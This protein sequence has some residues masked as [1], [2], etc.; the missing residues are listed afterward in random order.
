MSF[1]ADAKVRAPRPIF[2][3][4]DD[5][6]D[7]DDAKKSSVR[8]GYALCTRARDMIPPLLLLRFCSSSLSSSLSSSSSSSSGDDDGVVLSF[9]FSSF[10][11]CGSLQSFLKNSSKEDSAFLSKSSKE[12]SALPLIRLFVFV[13]LCLFFVFFTFSPLFKK[14]TL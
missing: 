14:K 3:P 8:F 5:D 13:S 9:V 2:G 1:N 7:D 6:D 11:V 12:R 4:I 10:R